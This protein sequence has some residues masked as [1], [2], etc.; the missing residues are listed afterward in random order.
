MNGPSFREMISAFV[1][2]YKLSLDVELLY[3]ESIRQLNGMESRPFQGVDH[4]LS[5][6]NKQKKRLC[7][8]TS[9]PEARVVKF[10][11]QQGWADAFEAIVSADHVGKG[12]PQPDIYHKALEVMQC[13]P[14][15]AVA[16]EDSAHGIHSASAASIPVIAFN[17]PKSNGCLASVSNWQE[18]QRFLLG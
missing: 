1:K 5:E 15:E 6:A 9:S 4:F 14:D 8:V 17:H 3:Q 12:K 16:I 11:H 2:R 10:L 7:I 18:L 13:Q